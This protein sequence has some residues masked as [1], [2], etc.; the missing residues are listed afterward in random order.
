MNDGGH[1]KNL[2]IDKKFLVAL[3]TIGIPV[4]LQNLLSTALNLIDTLMIG[5]VGKN[6]LAAVG[7]AN[8]VFFIMILLVFGINSGASVFISQFW[9][10]KDLV[11]IKKTMGIGL[12]FGVI[13]SSLFLLVG[14]FFPEQTMS[15]LGNGNEALIKH[16]SVYLRIV[17]WSYILTA[18]SFSFSVGARSIAQATTPT[19]ISAFAVAINATLN[20]ILIYGKLGMPAM[21]VAG[22]AWA[23]LI[24][25]AFEMVTIIIVLYSQNS[26]LAARLKEM[27]NFNKAY[28][29]TVMTTSLPVIVNESMWAVGNVMYT[30]AIAKIS[31]D[32]VASYQVGISVYRFY[33]VIFIGLASAC[34]VMIGNCIGAGKEDTAKS[35]ARQFMIINQLAVV[36][37]IVLLIGTAEWNVSLFGLPIEVSRSAANLVKIYGI[38]SFFKCFNL[39]MIVGV[40]RGG[41]DTHY[42]MRVELIAVW[43]VGVPMAFIGAV[44]LQWSVEWTVAAMML[45]E[46]IKSFFC[47]YRYLSKKWCHNVIKNFE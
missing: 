14:Q 41:G 33:E 27:F 2:H 38:F 10:R 40:L 20:Y 13:V 45:E 22:A 44:L 26:P 30:I 47:F 11:N 7:L 18:I 23:T 4:M 43:F 9:G 25:R 31:A 35:Y 42:A 1:M 29:K 21:G 46:V 24:A 36:F 32:A 28:L 19:I 15:L 37:I 3:M 17:S 12:I 5:Q 8:Q 16:G 39:L 34:Q 6:E